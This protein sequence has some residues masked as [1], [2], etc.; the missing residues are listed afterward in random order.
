MI[1]TENAFA[2]KLTTF[3][4]LVTLAPRDLGVLATLHARRRRACG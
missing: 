2:R 4:L 1:E 3:V